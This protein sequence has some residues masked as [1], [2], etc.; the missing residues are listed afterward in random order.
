MVPAFKLVAIRTDLLEGLSERHQKIL[1]AL[2]KMKKGSQMVEEGRA[3]FI[4]LT[5][6]SKVRDVTKAVKKF[7]TKKHI[8]KG[9]TAN[10]IGK[11]AKKKKYQPDATKVAEAKKKILVAVKD[12][13][14]S[15]KH[16]LMKELKMSYYTVDQATKELIHENKLKLE[17]ARNPNNTTSN[18][19]NY[20]M[21]A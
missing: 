14:F 10:K 9:M 21:I 6:T 1:A 4:A 12:S 8:K 2:E 7:A 18:K 17:N 20:F 15:T 13:K 16:A 19:Y 5:G 11:E 3:E